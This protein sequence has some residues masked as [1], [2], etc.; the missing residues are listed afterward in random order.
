MEASPGEEE[1]EAGASEVD[2]EKARGRRWDS[3]GKP[4][5]KRHGEV[6][7]TQPRNW[8]LVPSAGG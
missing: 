8:N 2:K 6:N 5:Q 4:S 3:I 7:N 1:A